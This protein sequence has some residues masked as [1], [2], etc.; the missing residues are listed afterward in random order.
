MT[1][2]VEAGAIAHRADDILAADSQDQAV[3]M[4]MDTGKF[5]ELNETAREVWNLTDGEASVGHVISLLGERFEVEPDACRSEVTALYTR[6]RDE[7][8]VIFPA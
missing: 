5:V 8:L 2:K 6:F 7:G 4:S 3:L 1:K